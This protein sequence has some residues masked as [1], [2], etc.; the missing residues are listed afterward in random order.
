MFRTQSNIYDDASLQ[1]PLESF[2]VDVRLGSKYA[3]SIGL[4]V[5]KVYAMSIFIWYNQ[6]RLQK[7]VI[8]FLFLEL[9][10]NMFV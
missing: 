6:G 8:A 5:E 3:F 10:K 9:I 7:S 4:T 1:K 2:I